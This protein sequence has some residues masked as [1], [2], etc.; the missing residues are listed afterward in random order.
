MYT[1]KSNKQSLSFKMGADVYTFPL[2]PAS[3]LMQLRGM[4][5]KAKA[6]KTIEDFGA[7]FREICGVV[8]GA[9][10]M[11]KIVEYFD[12]DD[13][14]IIAN[15]SPYLADV[16]IPALMKQSS[17]WTKKIKKLLR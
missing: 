6:G 13:V 1:I 8:F 2:P 14:E 15:I 9:E 3:V 10:I 12:G 5:E 17:G 7:A 11:A 4:S 16:V